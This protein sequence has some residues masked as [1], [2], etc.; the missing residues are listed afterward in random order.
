MKPRE[1]RFG[2]EYATNGRNA[3]AAYKVISPNAKDTT[4]ATNGAK[5][6][7]N[8]KLREYIKMRT[9]ERLD[10]HSLT[11]ADVLDELIDIAFGRKQKSYNK[12][13]DLT[14]GEIIKDIEYESSAMTE[15]RLKALELL[16]KNLAMF[17]DKQEVK[18]TGEV[19]FI[20]D[21]N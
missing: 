16:G 15:E 13:T 6:L 20:D 8:P 21:I 1:R 4:C 3:T 7:D 12:Q 5:M 11:A 2:D 10:A 9:K 17:T 19:Q 14:T 18:L